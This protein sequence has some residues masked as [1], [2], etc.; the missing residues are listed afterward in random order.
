ML[1]RQSKFDATL[2]HALTRMWMLG[3]RQSASEVQPIQPQIEVGVGPE[4]DFHMYFEQ[5]Q[6]DPDF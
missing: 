3:A 6:C 5:K 4:H 2:A 1:S